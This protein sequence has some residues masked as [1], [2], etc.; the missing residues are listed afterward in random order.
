M[1]LDD[2]MKLAIEAVRYARKQVP[3]SAN[4]KFTSSALMRKGKPLRMHKA[5]NLQLVWLREEVGTPGGND[6]SAKWAWLM[7]CARK[8]E[9]ARAGNCGELSAVVMMYLQNQG[10]TETL[11]LVLVGDGV[12]NGERVP[13][14]FV[15]IGRGGFARTAIGLPNTWSADAVICDPWDRVAYP[16]KDYN[17]FWTGIRGHSDSPD[18]LTCELWVRAPLEVPAEEE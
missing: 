16:A 18:T 3:K 8:T 2:N 10:V 9:K 15:V 5:T 1:S 4:Y 12:T 14:M 17:L 6:A 7:R 11:E 13:H